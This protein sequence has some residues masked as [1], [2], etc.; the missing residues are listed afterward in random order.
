MRSPPSSRPARDAELGRDVEE[1]G[2]VGFEPAG[3]RGVEAAQQIEIEAASVALVGERRVGEAV[4]EDD[5]AA[6]QGGTDDLGDISGAV[7]EEEEGL[8]PGGELGF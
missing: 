6:L 4:A 1:Q 3:R 8:G 5:F 7:G 2:E